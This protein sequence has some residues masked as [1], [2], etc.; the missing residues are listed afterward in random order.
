MPTRQQG[1]NPIAAVSAAVIRGRRVLLVQRGRPPFK[2][3]WSLPGGAIAWGE[4]ARAAVAREVQEETGLRVA[5]AELLAVRE[6]R[7]SRHHY[8][9]LVFCARP[10]DPKAQPRAASDAAAVR[11]AG[12]EELSAL[13]LTPGLAELLR[14]IP[15]F[16]PGAAS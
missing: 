13:R 14:R 10:R 16:R 6:I 7:D 3:C 1:P 12:R 11:W 2:S 9:L 15:Q 4:R 8:V 5:V